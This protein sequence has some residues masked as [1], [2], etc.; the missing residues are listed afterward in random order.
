MIVHRTEMPGKPGEPIYLCG[1]CRD[2]TALLAALEHT[3]GAIPWTARRCF[4]N[5]TRALV[6]PTEHPHA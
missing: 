4:G 6:S 3:H 2:N 5:T 1:T